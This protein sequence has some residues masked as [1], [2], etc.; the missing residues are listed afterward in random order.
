ML[1]SW[2]KHSLFHFYPLH[3]LYSLIMALIV[4]GL[5]LL[6]FAMPAR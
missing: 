3:N 4:F 2:R 1:N 5:I 6:F